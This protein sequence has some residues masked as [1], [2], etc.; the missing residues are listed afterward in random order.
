[1]NSAASYYRLRDGIFTGRSVATSGDLAE[2][3]AAHCPPG[4]GWI[5]GRYDRERQRVDID[6]GTI[7]EVTHGVE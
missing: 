5:V 1:M 7:V 6:T 3:A 2:F 4:C